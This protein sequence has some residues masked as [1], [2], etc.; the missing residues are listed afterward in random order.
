MNGFVP[1]LRM[2]GVPRLAVCV[3]VLGLSHAAVGAGE[4]DAHQAA[5]EETFATVGNAVISAQ[6]YE[7]A[8]AMAVRRKYY[9]GRTPEGELDTLRLEVAESLINRVLLL[10]EAKRRRI[11]PDR[12]A[13][14]RTVA[15]YE[16][17]YRQS[18]QWQKNGK[19]MLAALTAQLEQQS[20]LERLE[21]GVRK[22]PE[23]SEAQALGYYE[24]HRDL[25]VE[26]EQVRLAVIL[27]R[28]DP[29]SP[30]IAWDKAAEE[31]STIVARLRKGA[32]F[33]EL[34]R[35]HSSDSSAERGGDL[36]YLHRGMLP[37]GT[38]QVVDKLE[39][40]MISDPIRV[41]EGVAVVRV[42]DRKPAQQRTFDQVRERAGDLWQRE[43]ADEQWRRLIAELRANATIRINTARY[44][45]L[46]QAGT[47]ERRA[48]TP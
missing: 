15:G 16:Q 46:A 10:A 5:T 4:R 21:A 3:L 48:N 47:D 31:A 32:S 23:P 38:Q 37:E 20:Q 25:F 8:F 11:Q 34:A 9:H 7:A 35:L 24:A 6:E 36:G 1:T 39:Q 27:L 40:G 33:E 43:Q 2:A 18:E 30:R 13:V 22:T 44:P 41:L 26:P 17:R 14:K 28:V 45:A 42:V 12:A 19:R 29:A